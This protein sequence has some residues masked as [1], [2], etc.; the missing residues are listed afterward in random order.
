MNIAPL[1]AIPSCL[2]D[3]ELFADCITS[4]VFDKKVVSA[5]ARRGLQKVH[6]GEYLPRGS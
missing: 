6:A 5:V 3:S 2:L 4:S 1:D